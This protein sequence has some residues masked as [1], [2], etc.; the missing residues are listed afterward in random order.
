MLTA[1]P[2]VYLATVEEGRVNWQMLMFEDSSSEAPSD[3]VRQ[4][5]IQVALASDYSVPSI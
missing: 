3:Q 2:G 4:L 1:D 5:W